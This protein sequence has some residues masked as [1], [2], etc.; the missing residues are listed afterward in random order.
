VCKETGAVFELDLSQG[1][2]ALKEKFSAS[3]LKHIEYSR[4][5]IG[6]TVGEVTFERHVMGASKD[7]IE[8]LAAIE[9][10]SWLAKKGGE[11]KFIGP[12]NKVFWEQ[13]GKNYGGNSEAV[14]WILRCGNQPMAF[15][16]HIETEREV[17]VFANSYDEQWKSYSPGSLLTLEVLQDAIIR[18]KKTLDWGQGDSGYKQRWGARAASLLH[19]VILFQPGIQG[20][21]LAWLAKKAFPSWNDRLATLR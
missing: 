19:D 13:V 15:S 18:G 20:D 9:A 16:A 2:G 6:K 11:L 8:T 12:A 3:M 7:V 21:V 5:R 1:I 4:R 14:F 10:R 17:Y